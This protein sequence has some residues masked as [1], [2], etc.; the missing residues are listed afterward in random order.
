T[1]LGFSYR[2]SPSSTGFD[3]MESLRWRDRDRLFHP[4]EPVAPALGLGDPDLNWSRKPTAEELKLPYVHVYDR[5]CS[6]IAGVA[7][8]ELPEGDPDHHP[9]GTE[10]DSRVPGYWL[11]DLGEAADWRYPRSEERRV[12]K[13]WRD[14]GEQGDCQRKTRQT[15]VSSQAHRHR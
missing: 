14:R 7:G 1:A 2:V 6:Y 12:G 4:H 8:L 3:L 10:F 5:G 15:R 11:V 13:E 9:D